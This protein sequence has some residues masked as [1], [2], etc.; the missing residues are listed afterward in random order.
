MTDVLCFVLLACFISTFCTPSFENFNEDPTTLNSIACSLESQNSLP[1]CLPLSR[2]SCHEVL[3]DLPCKS[4]SKN[5]AGK[6]KNLSYLCHFF[7]SQCISQFHLPYLQSI[8]NKFVERYGAAV[9][10]TVMLQLPTGEQWR[11][12]VEKREDE[13]WLGNGLFE[14]AESLGINCGDFL[15]FD[16]DFNHSMFHMVV[17]QTSAAEIEYPPFHCS[18]EKQ[19]D[20]Q[21]GPKVNEQNE[22]YYN[23]GRSR[24]IKAQYP[25]CESSPRKA[26]AR[27]SL[28][29]EAERMNMKSSDDEFTADGTTVIRGSIILL[30][31]V[32]FNFYSYMKGT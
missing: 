29:H 21:S 13:M 26:K 3:Q 14:F 9:P 12:E 2:S 6:S 22:E 16:Y 1:L 20:K 15:M 19:K 18:A 30:S 8:P 4:H 27:S 7:L 17:V 31:S 10:T 24:G 25:F 11:V 28:G 32:K 23:Y 5:Q